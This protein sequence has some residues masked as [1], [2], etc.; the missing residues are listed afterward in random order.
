ME[1]LCTGYQRLRCVSEHQVPL[2]PCH[3]VCSRCHQRQP[4]GL[5][6]HQRYLYDCTDGRRSLLRMDVFQSE[7][8]GIRHRHFRYC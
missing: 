1:H 3:T 2:D 7:R 5:S 4:D 6:E 8:I